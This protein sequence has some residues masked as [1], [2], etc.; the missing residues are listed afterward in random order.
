MMTSTPINHQ[1]NDGCT[2]C[3]KPLLRWHKCS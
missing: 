1:G 2:E 3:R